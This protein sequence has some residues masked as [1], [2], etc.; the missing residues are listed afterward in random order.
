MATLKQIKLISI[1]LVILATTL[2]TLNIIDLSKVFGKLEVDLWDNIPG[3]VR[4]TILI[5]YLIA[6]L[7]SYILFIRGRK[8]KTRFDGI[9]N[10]L[11]LLN[12]LAIVLFVVIYL[13]E[14]VKNL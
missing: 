2:L 3:L 10:V 12:G 11:Y 13:T 6:L 5:A 1:V 9:A 7:T 4:R 14:L 8:A